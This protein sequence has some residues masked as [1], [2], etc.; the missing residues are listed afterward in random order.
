[1]TEAVVRGLEMIDADHHAGEDRAVPSGPLDLA[2]QPL[3]EGAPVEETSQ[4]I[5]LHQLAHGVSRRATPPIQRLLD[6]RRRRLDD[7]RGE[8]EIGVA[9]GRVARAG[10][11]ED[12]PLVHPGERT[13]APAT[14]WSRY[15]DRRRADRRGV[16]TR[17]TS[18]DASARRISG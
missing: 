8:T 1:M 13:A 17:T 7:S 18:P 9:Q 2:L 3:V 5:G 16:P 14:T 6:R 4:R 11:E 12:A 15:R 10:A